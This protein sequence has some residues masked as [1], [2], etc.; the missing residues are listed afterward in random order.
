MSRYSLPKRV[1]R[2][3]TPMF[4]EFGQNNPGGV[5]HIEDERG[6]GPRVWIEA[7]SA[8]EANQLAE[9]MGIYFDGVYKHSDCSCCGDR[10]YRNESLGE[11]APLIDEKYAFSWHDTV[12]VHKLD[13]TLERV[14]GKTKFGKKNK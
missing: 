2:S 8:D 14:K 4:F 5:F 11:D 1:S 9:S 3:T 10:W 6:I 7:Y 12:Y 13:G